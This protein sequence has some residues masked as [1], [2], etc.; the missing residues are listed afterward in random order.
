MW[1]VKMFEY[2][3][4]YLLDDIL[5]NETWIPHSIRHSNYKNSLAF[6]NLN[7]GAT[8]MAGY[9]NSHQEVSHE[10]S[11]GYFYGYL[12]SLF[13]C[14]YWIKVETSSN[15]HHLFMGNF[16]NKHCVKNVHF[17]SFSGPYFPA[18]GLNTERYSLNLSIFSSNARIYGR[19]K[20]QIGKLFTQWNLT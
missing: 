14:S 20:L 16:T 3:E 7:V 11:G 9:R 19:E 6:L 15:H 10:T 1:L 12:V 2:L 4:F 17:R 5:H 13:I 18:F 8:V